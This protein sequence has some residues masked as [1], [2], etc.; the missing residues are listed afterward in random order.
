V[1]GSRDVGCEREKRLGG[2]VLSSLIAVPGLVLGWLNL[3][4][5][6]QGKKRGGVKTD[7]SARTCCLFRKKV[8]AD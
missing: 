3:L 2:A 5:G 1:W 7:C 8:L 4:D 6:L